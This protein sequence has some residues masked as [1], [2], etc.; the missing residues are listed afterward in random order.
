M[1]IGRAN[2]PG[3]LI[4]PWVFCHSVN[5]GKGCW[6]NSHGPFKSWITRLSVPGN[7]FGIF[8]WGLEF[9][10]L[11]AP[12][13]FQ[14]CPPSLGYCQRL[15]SRN[16][17]LQ[18]SGVFSLQFSSEVTRLVSNPV[19][20]I[21]KSNGS[22]GQKSEFMIPLIY[23]SRRFLKWPLSGALRIIFSVSGVLLLLLI[24]F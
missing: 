3:R 11:Q 15:E 19:L 22:W 13:C 2:F 16:V 17:L 20:A 1:L 5:C 24:L 18:S 23:R 6:L 8:W 7:G 14:G 10:L 12:R 9:A 4:W 21:I